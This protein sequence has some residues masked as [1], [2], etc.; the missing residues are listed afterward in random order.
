MKRNRARTEE[1]IVQAAVDLITQ[2]GFSELG[3]NNVAARSGV[4]KVLIYRYFKGLDGLLAHI[5]AHT[6]FYPPAATLFPEEE[7]NDLQ[8]FVEAYRQAMRTRPLTRMLI[9]WRLHADNPLTRILDERRESF[10]REV[11]A[12]ARPADEAGRAFLGCLRPV[13]E[14]SVPEADVLGALVNFRYA[15]FVPGEARARAEAQAALAPET[16]EEEL[17][18]NLL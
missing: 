14:D 15:P 5:A 17:P 7:A 4:D 10:W 9:A 6:E 1:R 16:A 8:P 13:L 2:S 18:T 3:I 11:E 12:Y